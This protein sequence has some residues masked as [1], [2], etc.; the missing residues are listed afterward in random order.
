[1]HGASLSG[2]MARALGA[3]GV[4]ADSKSSVVCLCPLSRSSV[5]CWLTPQRCVALQQSSLFVSSV[6]TM[7]NP[8][9]IG[10]PPLSSAPLAPWSHRI[11]WLHMPKS[12][13]SFGTSLAHL[14][15]ASLPHDATIG[16]NEAFVPTT[17]SRGSDEWFRTRQGKYFISRYPHDV[18][19]RGIF[20]RHRSGN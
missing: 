2:S 10:Q 18:W 16:T 14:A 20:W 11:G 17:A 19:F 15:N 13:T 12:G 7:R 6:A 4:A 9:S 1:M 8:S 3:H 5:R